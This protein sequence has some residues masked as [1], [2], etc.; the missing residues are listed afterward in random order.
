[1]K[2]RTTQLCPRG[3]PNISVC[4]FDLGKKVVEFMRLLLFIYFFPIIVLFHNL[5]S[6]ILKFMRRSNR[7]S[8][9]WYF[10]AQNSA[11]AS[12]HQYENTRQNH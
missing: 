12:I 9:S 8:Q 2:D 4:F 10:G 5:Q 6:I 3:G 1:M 7:M 11:L